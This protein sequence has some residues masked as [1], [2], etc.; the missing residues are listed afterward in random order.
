[1]AYSEDQ[2]VPGN[3]QSIDT[4]TK[5]V[6]F[7]SPPNDDF[8]FVTVNTKNLCV[9]SRVIG[10]GD[11]CEVGHV[12]LPPLLLLIAL[13]NTYNKTTLMSIEYNN[14]FHLFSFF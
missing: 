14:C 4:K 7:E 6:L 1:M 9:K 10:S 11:Q 8:W 13:N 12:G 3:C 5:V 2:V